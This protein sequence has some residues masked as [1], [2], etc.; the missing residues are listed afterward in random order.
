VRG[1][2][3]LVA[4]AFG[5]GSAATLIKY[6]LGSWPPLTLLVVQ[7]VGANVVLWVVLL[8]RGYRRPP[9]LLKVA[10]LGALEPG[11]CYA[12]VTI[13]LL[14]TTAANAV[15]IGGLESFF[16]V[17]LAALFLHERITLRSAAG[18]IVAIVGVVIVAGAGASVGI[19]EILVL[20][21]ILAAALYVIVAKTIAG[22][23]DSLTLTAHQ[24]AAA[25]VLVIPFAAFR[26]STGSEVLIHDR[27]VWAWTAALAVGIFGYAGSFLLYNYAIATISAGLSSIILNLIPVFGVLTALLFLHERI[28]ILKAV[29]AAFIICSIAVFPKEVDNH[30]STVVTECQTSR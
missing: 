6:A 28:T 15:I 1:A 18:L 17:I 24:F 16:V 8:C 2:L 21:G 5:W 30:S 13:G 22:N 11:L 7:L 19:G 14:R 26:W 25:L 9:L 3:A 10:L 12:L 29:G 4:A 23:V 27:S 20:T